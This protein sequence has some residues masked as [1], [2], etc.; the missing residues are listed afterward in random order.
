DLAQSG[1]KSLVIWA[2]SD[3]EPAVEFF[4]ALG[5]KAVARSS[6]RFGDR[7]LDKGALAWQGWFNK[8][9]FLFF[10]GRHA[11]PAALT[12]PD[13]LVLAALEAARVLVRELAREF[14]GIR[15]DARVDVADVADSA[16]AE[17]RHHQD[18][19]GRIDC[20]L[21]FRRLVTGRDDVPAQDGR[22][23]TQLA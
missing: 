6:Q 21:A 10:V 3:N 22:E 9:A 5:G 16:R 11:D 15:I 7:V 19:P 1:M 23:R 17:P 14:V 20:V 13:P 18:T 2:L 4:R 8:I 12:P